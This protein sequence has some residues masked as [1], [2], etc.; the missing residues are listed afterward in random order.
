MSNEDSRHRATLYC[1]CR[2]CLEQAARELR[3]QGLHPDDIAAVL[4][5][6]PTAVESLLLD[7]E[8]P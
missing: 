5:M 1:T 2:R 6:S 7:E 4:G 8:K 3:R